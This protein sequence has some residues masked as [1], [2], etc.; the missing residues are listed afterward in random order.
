MESKK[1]KPMGRPPIGPQTM[2]ERVSIRLSPALRADLEALAAREGV[3][4]GVVIREC[5]ELGMAAR[6]K[7]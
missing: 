1:Q 6:R 3:S 2:A 5:I 7:N 4:L